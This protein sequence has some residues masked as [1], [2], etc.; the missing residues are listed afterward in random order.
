MRQSLRI[1]IATNLVCWLAVL[2]PL[3]ECPV[4]FQT[5]QSQ[6]GEAHGCCSTDRVLGAATPGCCDASAVRVT[7]P[8][9]VPVVPLAHAPDDRAPFGP[10]PL[11][12]QPA[13]IL[14]NTAVIPRILRN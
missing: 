2:G 9:A 3:S 7:S 14:L 5:A 12:L 10:P 4:L 8:T 1:A 11:L 6:S 13:T